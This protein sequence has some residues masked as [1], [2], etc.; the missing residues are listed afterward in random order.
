MSFENILKNKSK[1]IL[2][3]IAIVYI[4]GISLYIGFSG[5]FNDKLVHD[6]PHGYFATDG[7]YHEVIASNVYE[8]GTFFSMDS[9]L[10]GGFDN[11]ISSAPPILHVFTALF[12]NLTGIQTYDTIHYVTMFFLI[13]SILTFYIIIRKFNEH[14]ALLS[15]PLT[16]FLFINAFYRQVLWGKWLFIMGSYFLI[17]A[18]LIWMY[19]KELIEKTNKLTYTILLAIVLGALSI[20]HI[21]EWIF[22]AMF[23]AIY[24]VIKFVKDYKEKK[25]MK[26]TCFSAISQDLKI[27]VVALIVSLIITIQYVYIF[28]MT[29]L[30]PTFGSGSSNFGLITNLRSQM[31]D[32]AIF[33]NAFSYFQYFIIIGMIAAIYFLYRKKNNY[34]PLIFLL[35]IF[36][37]TNIIALGYRSFQMRYFWP[38]YYGFAVALSIYL[39][40][41]LL[42]L[43]K[44]FEIKY[45]QIFIVFAILCVLMTGFF[46]PVKS[47]GLLNKD[48]WDATIWLSDNTPSE[49]KTLIFY[50]DAS[51]QPQFWA[52]SKNDIY[53]ID[54]QSYIQ[55]YQSGILNLTPKSNHLIILDAQVPYWDGMTIKTYGPELSKQESN[56]DMYICNYEYFVFD[57]RGQVPQFIQL[58]LAYRNMLIQS[59]NSE[60]YS[61]AQM[62]IIKNNNYRENCIIL[63]E[64]ISESNKNEQ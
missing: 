11:G 23:I 40:I 63:P 59:G 4:I 24:L 32:V 41:E 57:V 31:A 36:I 6:Y 5:I 7:L 58:N 47:L 42:R 62:S 37:F 55:T 13:V 35:F 16:S 2:E 46:S 14:V 53:N 43:V 1:N 17:A 19:R 3:I 28:I 60:V 10:S 9:S 15:L 27:T 48:V 51:T 26:E 45:W 50:G 25:S 44:K 29:W 22:F 64:T 21:S 49:T 34:E 54:T 20:A 61:N 38:I 39:I 8:S 33:M 52:H 12:S 18:I 56:R 30:V